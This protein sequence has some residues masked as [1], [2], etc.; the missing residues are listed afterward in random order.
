[1]VSAIDKDTSMTDTPN[2]DE[3]IPRIGTN[4][5]KWDKMEALYGIDPA[6]GLAMWV[7]DMDFRP[8]ASVQL[9]LETMTD[10]GI[11]GY[12]NESASSYT[13]AIIW[14]MNARHNW[15][16]QPEWIFTTHGLVNGTAMCLDAFTKEGDGIVVTTPVYHAFART[17]K[18]AGR[19]VIEC[20]LRLENNRY[21]MDFSAWD[22]QMQG[23]ET[24]FILCSPHNPGGRVWTK[25]ELQG[26][27]D[28]CK[29]HDLIL[30][31]DEIHHDLVFKDQTHT[32]MAHFKDITDRLIMM[33]SG[34]KTFNLAGC[35][36]GN[37]II[38][39]LALR[40]RFA[41]RMSAM[42]IS[43]NAFGL[44]MIEAAYSPSGAAWVDQVM[45]YLAENCRI[46]NEA[47]ES[48]PGLKSMPLEATYLAWV[49]FS[50]TGMSREDY[51][52]RV[53]K[54]AKIAPNYGQT[55]G[56]GGDD[57]VRFNLA[58]QRS[59]VIEATARLKAAFS[60]LQ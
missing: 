3:I 37:V 1:M 59:R 39:D 58:T 8:P 17:I 43:S 54:D 28:F 20:D 24:M 26:V 38:E 27:A 46:F 42:G 44:K 32:P 29:R 55:F 5:D 31:S 51:T 45:E 30:V 34:T 50:G 47:I 12:P 9:A 22:A 13:D 53:V 19:D 4:C 56:S 6:D 48:I 21:E 23:H 36:A 7:A 52:A 25:T 35:H 2:F 40:K 11:Y 33:T 15:Q 10:H 18:A 14:W 60:D 49:D 57:F 41:K 16:V